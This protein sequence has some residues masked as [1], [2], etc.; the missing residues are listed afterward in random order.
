MLL[1]R[2]HGVDGRFCRGIPGLSGW[3]RARRGD[4]A[5]GG[6]RRALGAKKFLKI[7]KEGAKNLKIGGREVPEGGLG[8]PYIGCARRFLR[9]ESFASGT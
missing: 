2:Q 7:L 1:G 8:A 3:A 5:H 9:L 6:H 4:S